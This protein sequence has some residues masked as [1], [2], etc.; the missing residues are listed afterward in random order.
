MLY[1][2]ETKYE[3]RMSGVQDGK[4]IGISYV[5]TRYHFINHRTNVEHFM[6]FCNE[7]TVSCGTCA[8][9]RSQ[10]FHLG[11]LSESGILLHPAVVKSEL[12]GAD[13]SWFCEIQ[14]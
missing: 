8:A 7:L 13:I 6:S 14:W 12:F 11:I 10:K 5:E 1:P 3:V 4:R 2:L 9:N